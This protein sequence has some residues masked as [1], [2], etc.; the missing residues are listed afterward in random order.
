MQIA[1]IK[2]G[3]WYETKVGVGECVR[4]GGT[5]PPSVRMR[6]VSPFP[7][8]ILNVV[9]RDVIR[10]LSEAESAPLKAGN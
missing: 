2:V 10:E 5:H 8:G 3:H 9:P 6:I 4:S 1:K 7:R